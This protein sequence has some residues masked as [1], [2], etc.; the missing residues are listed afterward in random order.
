MIRILLTCCL[1]LCFFSCAQDKGP[2][3][4][5]PHYKTPQ[6]LSAALSEISSVTEEHK[7]I[8]ITLSTLPPGNTP[9]DLVLIPAGRFMMGLSAEE[10]K[11]DSDAN[12][13]E[14][15]HEVTIT[16]P[17][18]MGKYEITQAQFEAVMSGNPSEFKT[19]PD[20]PVEVV[21]YDEAKQFV[22]SLSQLGVG[23]FR[24]PTEAEWEYACR[25]GTTTRFSFGQAPGC[26]KK[27]FDETANRYMWWGGN[28]ETRMRGPMPVGQKLPNPWGLYDMHGNVYE[29]CNDL[30]G[31]YSVEAQID[32]QGS[33]E[34]R[35]RVFRSGPW[36]GNAAWCQSS[37]R[38]WTIYLN[39]YH[40]LGIRV[41]R[42]L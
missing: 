14:I 27:K 8:R 11:F 42:E 25:A 1:L 18:Y 39:R 13:N 21:S 40:W 15:P 29:W 9:L 30:H 6:N 4:E 16:K 2:K 34:G 31:P 28:L 24:L 23:T 33:Q 22:T 37:R 41:V 19:S 7:T 36:N 12:Q 10:K 26:V 5:V 3:M 32:P 38:N 35:T 20:N 17:F